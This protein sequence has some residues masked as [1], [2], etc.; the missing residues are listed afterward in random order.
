MTR[1]LSTD[2]ENALSASTVR[3]AI[4]FEGVF[5]TDTIRLW[6]GY[7]NL[8]WD[9]KTW[10]GNGWLVGLADIT[11]DGEIRSSNVDIQLSGVPLSLVSLILTQQ[12]HA[13]RGKLW[14][15]CFD[16]SNAI[17]ADPW[18][19]F[20]GAL[21]APRIDD[22]G[23]VSQVILTYEDDL[24]MLQRASELRFNHEAQISLFP[25]DK[26]FEYVAGIE[27]WTGFWGLKEK[28]KPS[29]SGSKKSSK[30]KNKSNR[31]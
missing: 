2:M 24:I 30:V 28:P 3:A 26:G 14:L 1:G 17:I 9:S 19:L 31:K 16:S 25:D 20:D 5:V 29:K 10:L 22:S 18:L 8:S 21:S 15:A 27:N 4:L 13:S 11:E 23:D 7:G 6:T 12:S